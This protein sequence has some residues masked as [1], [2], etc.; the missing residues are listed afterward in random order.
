VILKLTAENQQLFADNQRL[1]AYSTQGSAVDLEAAE[2]YLFGRFPDAPEG[3]DG[4][5][6]AVKPSEAPLDLVDADKLSAST[7]AASWAPTTAP[8]H[9]V[10]FDE[11]DEDHHGQAMAHAASSEAQRLA[12][13]FTLEA[14]GAEGDDA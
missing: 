6:Y 7:T 14:I 3:L 5:V 2:P 13:M 9:S 10:L 11:E 12:K 4:E 8:A 1:M